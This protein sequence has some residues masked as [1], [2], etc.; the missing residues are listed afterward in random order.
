MDYVIQCD[1]GIIP[2][3]VK[4]SGKGSMQ[5]MAAFLS[6]HPLSPYGIRAS[7]ENFTVYDKIHVFPVYAVYKL[8]RN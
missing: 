6:A 1:D 4:A 5:S 7:L 3:E 8:P 2:I